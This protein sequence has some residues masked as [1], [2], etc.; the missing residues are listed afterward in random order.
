M[1]TRSHDG[2]SVTCRCRGHFD[3]KSMPPPCKTTARYQ[4]TCEY[5][6][7]LYI[8][9]V[10][11][12]PYAEGSPAPPG[13][14]PTLFV[15]GLTPRMSQALT[16]TI[17]D[18]A[19]RDSLMPSVAN[20]SRIRRLPAGS[21]TGRTANSIGRIDIFSRAR[22][23]RKSHGRW[24]RHSVPGPLCAS[25]S[26]CALHRR[27]AASPLLASKVSSATSTLDGTVIF[28]PASIPG[29]ATN[30]IWLPPGPIAA[31]SLS[32]STS[33]HRS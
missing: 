28:P 9:F 8:R 24:H 6:S 19:M 2:D 18:S 3:L 21:G 17:D 4:T 7:P 32:L 33:I 23:G 15:H 1:A 30:L 5:I 12:G 29:V 20:R 11:L 14:M 22:Y 16:A 31:C 13:T 26:L 25:V 10:W 27:C